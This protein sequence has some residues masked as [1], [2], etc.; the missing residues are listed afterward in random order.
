MAGT[1]TTPPTIEPMTEA[2]A[3]TGGTPPPEAPPPGFIPYPVRSSWWQRNLGATVAIAVALTAGAS[4]LAE[5]GLSL[6]SDKEH[7]QSQL[8]IDAGVSKEA[9]ARR[10]GEAALRK[11]I[12]DNGKLIGKNGAAINSM[13]L[14]ALQ[15][16]RYTQA[17]LRELADRDARP[18]EIP[19]AL[20]D[21]EDALRKLRTPR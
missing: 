9:E 21:A 19:G 17:L 1:M 18:L 5:A 14:H 8:R 7:A 20:R 2:H 4:Q 10:K 12:R 13:A 6:Y 11:T 15:S 16:S 3:L